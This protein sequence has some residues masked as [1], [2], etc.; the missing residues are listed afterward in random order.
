MKSH[1]SILLFLFT[2]IFFSCAHAPRMQVEAGRESAA[3]TS[4]E[5]A[6][7]HE[8]ATPVPQ[9]RTDH[10]TIIAAGDNLYHDVMMR[11]GEEGDYESAYSEI[12]SLLLKADIAFINQ[13]TLL[14]GGSFGF[15]GYPRF[16]APQALGRAVAAA[17]FSVVNHA[18]NHIMDRGE[19]A[20]IATLEFWDSVPGITVLGIRRSEEE[21][22]R[23]VLMTKNNITVGF[24]S[25]T[26]GTNGI[27]VPEDR[28]FL[29]SLIDT[30]IMEGEI[31][32]LRPLCDFLVVSMHWGEEYS[33][34]YSREQEKLAAF[35][36][37]HL[38]DL[39]IGH[40]PH[41][42]QS[43]ELIP[44]P[45]GENMLCFY[46][47]GNLISAQTQNAALLGALA[48]VKIEK[49][50]FP[51]GERARIAEAGAIPTVTHYE[52]NYSNFRVYSLYDY[53]EELLQNHR[54]NQEKKELTL[55]YL[56]GLATGVLKDRELRSDPFDF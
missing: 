5:E 23:P 27:P 28:D 17:G 36:A 35:L 30:G 10:V 43:V 46:S 7:F 4:K 38:V 47:L 50:S 56:K 14:A 18:T 6:P 3:E 54:K 16:N 53:T 49:I 1:K 2:L 33:G 26:Y 40:H 31:D 52:K 11:D 41:V 15:S 21:R 55:E 32:A 22:S 37:E 39:V 44:R 51:Q 29:V 20:V 19:E 25:Y 45:D 42:L 24:L 12:K 9:P 8:A 34:S 48:Y 13:E